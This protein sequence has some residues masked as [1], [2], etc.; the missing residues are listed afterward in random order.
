MT[1]KN[2][3][4]NSLEK[5]D[6]ERLSIRLDKDRKEKVRF[7]TKDGTGKTELLNQAIDLLYENKINEKQ[8][9]GPAML[10]FFTGIA[11]S[12]PDTEKENISGNFKQHYK[13]MMLEKHTG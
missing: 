9:S 12:V 3:A 10:D 13:D 8:P 1:T 11:N 2:V 5:A 6:I 4:S 7:L